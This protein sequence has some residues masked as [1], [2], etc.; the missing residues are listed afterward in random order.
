[1]NWKTRL[2]NATPTGKK[3]ELVILRKDTSKSGWFSGYK[4]YYDTVFTI[5]EDKKE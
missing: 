4:E 5:T 2:T 1:M 3:G